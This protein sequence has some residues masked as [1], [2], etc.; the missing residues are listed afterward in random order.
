MIQIRSDDKIIANRIQSSNLY[1]K[2][3]YEFPLRAI[4]YREVS[5]GNHNAQEIM[6][7]VVPSRK[8][9]NRLISKKTI[10][11]FPKPAQS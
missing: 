6:D 8:N 3:S 10:E 11:D 1:T 2:A 4:E 5:F 7:E 9:S